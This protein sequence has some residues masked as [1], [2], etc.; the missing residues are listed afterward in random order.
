MVLVPLLLGTGAVGVNMVRTLQ[1][2]QLARDAGH[3]YARGIDFSQPGNQ[4]I[5][6][7]WAHRWGFPRP[8]AVLSSVVILS[9]LTYVDDAACTAAGAATGGVHNGTC[10]N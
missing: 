10:T 4:T 3:M 1:T 5:L 6:V 9:A 2:V 8:P 7:R